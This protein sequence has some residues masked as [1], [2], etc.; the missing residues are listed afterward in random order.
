MQRVRRWDLSI[1]RNFLKSTVLYPA[2]L[3]VP[4]IKKTDQMLLGEE[5]LY[6]TII[7]GSQGSNSEK[8]SWRTT[9]SWLVVRS[10]FSYLLYT[11][12][13]MVPPTVGWDLLHDLLN[14]KSPRPI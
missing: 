4:I 2:V 9:A 8:K 3:P 5:R 11:C 7:K 12:L 1:H 13:D 6:F 10:M 14:K